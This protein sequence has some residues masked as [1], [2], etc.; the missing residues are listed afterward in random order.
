M[1]YLIYDSTRVSSDLHVLEPKGGFSCFYIYNSSTQSRCFA[2]ISVSQ[3]LKSPRYRSALPT[4]NAAILDIADANHSP[5]T[6]YS[7]YS[8]DT[9]PELFI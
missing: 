4:L 2:S 9:H 5:A 1:I 3:A 8:S 6:N 7:Y